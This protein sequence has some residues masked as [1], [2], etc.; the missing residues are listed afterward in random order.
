M[1][2]VYYVYFCLNVMLLD[3][4]MFCALMIKFSVT[5]LAMASFLSV[6]CVEYVLLTLIL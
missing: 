4:L 3:M 2:V 6:I 1:S 5:S